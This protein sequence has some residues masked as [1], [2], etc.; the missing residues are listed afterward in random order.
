MGSIVI[1]KFQTFKTRFR[2]L[3]DLADNSISDPSVQQRLDT[4]ERRLF[5]DA[6]TAR[7]RLNKWLVDSARPLE[8]ATMV[9]NHKKRKRIDITDL[10]SWY[11][12]NHYHVF[13]WVELLGRHTKEKTHYCNIYIFFKFIRFS[14]TYCPTL[15]LFCNQ[16]NL[17]QI[18]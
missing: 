14:L 1:L 13:N 9:A 2:Q 16:Q 8:A 17:L 10:S 12:L 11:I 18:P 5:N 15:L 7:T 3:M 6:Y 4:L